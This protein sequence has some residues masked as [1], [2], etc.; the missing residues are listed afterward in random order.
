[1]TRLALALVLAVAL[2]TALACWPARPAPP[3]WNRPW[4]TIAAPAVHAGEVT[5]VTV[6]VTAQGAPVVGGQVVIERSRDGGWVPV[7]DV[8]TDDAGRVTASVT[9]RGTRS[10]TRCAPPSPRPIS[11]TPGRADV[12]RTPPQ[13]RLLDHVAWSR[14]LRR[15]DHG[16]PHRAVA[17]SRGGPGRRQGRAGTPSRRRARVAARRRALHRQRRGGHDRGDTTRRLPVAG[18][19]AAAAL[20]AARTERGPPPRQPSTRRAGAHAARRTPAAPLPATAASRGRQRR[21]RQDRPDPGR[22]LATDDR[23]QLAPR[24]SGRPRRPAAR[25]DQLLG[26]HRLPAGAAS[27]W[28]RPASPARS[29]ARYATCTPPSCRSDRCTAS[30][31]SAGRGGSAVPTTTRRCRPATPRPSTAAASSGDL[32]SGHPTPTVV[33]WTSTRGRTP[34]ARPRACT[35][36]P[37]G[38]VTPTRRSPGAPVVTGWCR[39]WPATACAGP[40]G[41]SD[42]H[43]FDAVPRGGRV[44]RVRGCDLPVCH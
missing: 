41:S 31:G 13:A 4:S 43:H 5:T 1:M 26:L 32:A 39:S 15:R 8:V 30:T 38:S 40:T 11:T 3:R 36:T 27:W 42:I 22:G 19:R 29:W 35:R 16:D 28:S 25:Q 21:E 6:T 17:G 14:R 20:G 2:A 44:L 33:R 12:R 23:P 18:L 37:G 9:L 24:L 7:A 34:T 10:T